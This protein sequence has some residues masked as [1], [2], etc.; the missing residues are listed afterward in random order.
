MK[1]QPTLQSLKIATLSFFVAASVGASGIT[2]DPDHDDPIAG[3][4]SGS[5]VHARVEIVAVTAGEQPRVAVAVR[6]Q[7]P[8]CNAKDRC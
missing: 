1:I 2:G 8:S 4:L 6:V 7:D 3:D 5:R